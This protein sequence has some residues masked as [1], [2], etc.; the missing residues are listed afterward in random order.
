VLCGTHETSKRN[1]TKE[2]ES[3]MSTSFTLRAAVIAT[4]AAGLLMAGIL[5]AV[6]VPNIGLNT[7][8]R[9]TDPF[10]YLD[11]QFLNTTG[12]ESSASGQWVYA[13]GSITRQLPPV[14]PIGQSYCLYSGDNLVKHI[15]PQDADYITLN[16]VDGTNGVSI[17]SPGVRGDY[18][19]L[20]S[21]GLEW[22]TLG[23]SGSW[24]VG[25]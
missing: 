20:L 10:N 21:D 15:D 7:G 12:E 23:Q 8:V 13:E 1:G 14:G 2:P 22:H 3:N 5:A 16:G 11:I 9:A 24:V 25:A 4:L 18:I 17:K 6:T 19:C